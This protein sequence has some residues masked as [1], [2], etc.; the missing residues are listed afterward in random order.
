MLARD[1]SRSAWNKSADLL[2][3]LYRVPLASMKSMLSGG[4][5]LPWLRGDMARVARYMPGNPFGTGL[6]QPILMDFR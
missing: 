1:I 5:V 6:W 4:V 3:S 2:Q